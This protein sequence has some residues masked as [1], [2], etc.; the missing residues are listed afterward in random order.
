MYSFVE[1]LNCFDEKNNRS[2]IAAIIQT[3]RYCLTTCRVVAIA[4][5]TKGIDGDHISQNTVNDTHA[6]VVARRCLMKYFYDQLRL[7]MNESTNRFMILYAM[8][9]YPLFKFR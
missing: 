1:S 2:V 6:E 9:D 3:D 4:S 7:A 5:G 8:R